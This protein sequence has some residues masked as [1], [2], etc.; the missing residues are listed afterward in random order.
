MS[1]SRGIV[2]P[3]EH[4]AARSAPP[5]VLGP[6][7]DSR[8]LRQ[9]GWVLLPLR[10]FLGATFVFASL[11]KLANPSFFD[12]SSPSSVQAQMHAVAPASP[13]GSLVDLS[14]HGGWLVG[15]MIALGE[16]AVGMGTLLGLRARLAAAGG[17]LLALS[18]FLTVSWTTSPYYYGA[19]I[20]FVFAW[21]P[22]A[23]VGAA[24]VLSVDGLIS[25]RQASP[26]TRSTA[27][28]VVERRALVGAAVGTACLAGLTVVLGRV[29]GATATSP[30]TSAGRST[31]P[32]SAPSRGSQAAA[33]RQR[34]GSRPPA[35]MHAV[36]DA[37]GMRLGQ[38]VKF[39]DPATGNPAWLI[40]SGSSQYDAFS[41][42]CT[43]A[44][45]TVNYDSSAKQFVCP[46][47][48]GTYSATDGHV[49]GGPPP[50]PLA[51]IKVALSGKKVY[52]R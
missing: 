17:I 27:A 46:C 44:G 25:A 34:T 31:G 7:W 1:Q 33:S 26:G 8:G 50:S 39:S 3:E 14:L 15:L 12:A 11:Q 29:F 42:V 51:R 20:V 52:A 37:A 10:L 16:L 49:T 38:G 21:T 48:G 30:T 24:G 4:L 23:F 22:F 6:E 32:R 5:W 36:A 28:A 47:H 43:H 18:F 45:C 13:I 9:T 41:A 2:P 40:R 35:G 19:D